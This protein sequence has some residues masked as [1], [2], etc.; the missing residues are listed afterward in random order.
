VKRTARLAVAF[1]A[2]AATLPH[3]AAADDTVDAGRQA[4][5]SPRPR[6]EAN[7][8]FEPFA[9]WYPHAPSLL[10]QGSDAPRD[11]VGLRVPGAS[12]YAGLGF[13]VRGYDFP[14]P[15]SVMTLLGFRYAHAMRDS[16]AGLFANGAPLDVAGLS[17]NILEITLPWWNGFAFSDAQKTWRLGMTV[18]F[19]GAYA[20]GSGQVTTPRGASTLS[21]HT[22]DLFIR[23]EAEGCFRAQAHVWACA[24]V[25]ENLHEFDWVNGG[26]AGLR[27]D[28]R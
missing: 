9:A 28:V 5:T 12:T 18:N 23:P 20:W 7:F 10:L 13:D 14:T 1:S 21:M 3:S 16:S 17:T 27:I 8:G 22:F 25:T 2:I 11:L 19:G 26:S 24:H 15:G 6:L 4:P